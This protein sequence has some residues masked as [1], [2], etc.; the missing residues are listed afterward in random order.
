[1]HAACGAKTRLAASSDVRMRHHLLQHWTSKQTV[2][3]AVAPEHAE[4]LGRQLCRS[5][6]CIVQ[7]T[8][9]CVHMSV[10]LVWSLFQQEGVQQRAHAVLWSV[11]LQWA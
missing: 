3:V 7:L 9:L 2:A 1:M 11:R 4:R 10:H 8:G 6:V 5:T